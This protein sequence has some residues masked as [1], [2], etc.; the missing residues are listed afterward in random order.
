MPI[1]G[2]AWT[3]LVAAQMA[4]QGMVG[5]SVPDLALA[6]GNGSAGHV[7]G[8]SF[9]TTDSGIVAGT[10]AG[11]GVGVVVAGP[12]IASA[13][14]GYASG[15]GWNGPNLMNLCTAIGNACSIEMLSALLTSTHTPIFVGTGIV[16]PASIGV[17]GPAWGAAIQA[18]FAFTGPQWP[19][20][21]QA[22]GKG[23]ADIIHATAIA[24][25]TITGAGFPG[26]PG[27]GVGSGVIS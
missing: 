27:A 10:G 26:V 19:N 14:Y 7:V 5:P 8:K 25:V 16:V 3:S 2:P 15:Y 6:V 24:T 21:C 13:I 9:T 22:I 23:C 4:A 1:L 20:L 12:A 11:T 17:A 18:A